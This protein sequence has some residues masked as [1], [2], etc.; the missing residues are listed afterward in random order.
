MGGEA[1]T[2]ALRPFLPADMPLLADIF[3][4]SIEELTGEDYSREQQEAWIAE[5]DDEA[6][7]AKKL[8]AMLTLVLTIDSE[9]VAFATMQDNNK[10]MLLHVSPAKAGQGL[11]GHLIDALERLAAARGTK[12]MRVDATDNALEFFTKRGYDMKQRNSVSLNGEWLA[13][14]SMEKPLDAA[15]KQ[16]H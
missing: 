8:S 16:S 5:A 3:R 1:V 6:A 14:T 2:P 9:P 4:D 10:I 12:T 15:A 13:N 7:F 11:A